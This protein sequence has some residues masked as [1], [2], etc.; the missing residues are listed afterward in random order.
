LAT[1][2]ASVLVLFSYGFG[3]SRWDQVL[4]IAGSLGLV[5]VG[6]ALFIFVD[7]WILGDKSGFWTNKERSVSRSHEAIQYLIAAGALFI[8]AVAGLLLK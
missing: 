7:K 4:Y 8:P 1:A 2:L 3:T 5:C 6:I